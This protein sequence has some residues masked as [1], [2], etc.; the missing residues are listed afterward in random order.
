MDKREVLFE[1][2]H[3]VEATLVY[4]VVDYPE[5]LSVDVDHVYYGGGLNK[6]DMNFLLENKQF[7]SYMQ[8]LANEDFEEPHYDEYNKYDE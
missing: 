7:Y 3:G 2:D 4:Y 8:E 5:G 6:H 1:L